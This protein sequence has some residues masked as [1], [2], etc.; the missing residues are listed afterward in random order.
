MRP[1]GRTPSL[2]AALLLTAS[3]LAAQKPAVGPA[4]RAPV[5]QPAVS[6]SQKPPSDAGGIL[7]QIR[8]VSEQIKALQAELQALNAQLAQAMTD[9]RDLT[10]ARPKAPVAG[11]APKEVVD[12]YNYSLAQWQNQMAAKQADINRLQGSIA[13]KQQEIAA[14]QQEL[15][16]LQQALQAAQRRTG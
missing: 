12:A 14:K 4:P 11:T 10:A 6:P 16:R 7:A 15:A 5:P 9:L 2:L 1:T 8:V 13:A 3:P